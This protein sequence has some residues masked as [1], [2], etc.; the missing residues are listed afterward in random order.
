[1]EDASGQRRRL[2]RVAVASRHG[3]AASQRGGSR[4]ASGMWKEAA[5]L[6]ENDGVDP[7]RVTVFYF[8]VSLGFP[9]RECGMSTVRRSYLLNVPKKKIRRREAVRLCLEDL[10]VRL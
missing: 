10:I 6:G 7:N 8:P 9:V 3:T 5:G 1:M 4:P 2:P